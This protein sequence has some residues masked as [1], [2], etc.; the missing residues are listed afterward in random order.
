MVVWIESGSRKSAEKA[1]VAEE[2]T[3]RS[4][5]EPAPHEW[6]NY[7]LKDSGPQCYLFHLSHS[8]QVLPL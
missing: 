2:T 6:A 5:A 3:A 4:K 8:F 1:E 7:C